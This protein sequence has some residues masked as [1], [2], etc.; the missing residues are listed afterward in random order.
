M[1]VYPLQKPARDFLRGS[2]TRDQKLCCVRYNFVVDV[3]RYLFETPKLSGAIHGAN[4]TQR[5]SA[6]RTNA[7]LSIIPQVAAQA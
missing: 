1:A 2:A 7:Y 4:D 3:Y 5:Q 6:P